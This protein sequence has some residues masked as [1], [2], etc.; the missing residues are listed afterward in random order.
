MSNIVLSHIVI[1]FA[2]VIA[3]AVVFRILHLPVVLG[4]LLVGAILGPH[5]LGVIKN[6]DVMERLAGFGV[7]F[8]MFTVG[9]EFSVAKLFA[10]R[11]AVFGLGGLQVL[12]SVILGMGI[13]TAMGMEWHS[14]LVVGGIVA[15]SSTA[16]VSK[17][18]SERLELNSK[19]GL[20][21]IGILLF[22]D[23][24]VIPLLIMVDSSTHES[25]A[26]LFGWAVLKG[27]IA[28]V[29]I[30]AIGR[31][32]MQPIF[33]MTAGTRVIELF[34][35]LVLFVALASA[36]LTNA[37][38]M[39]FPLGGFLA[40][41]MLAET[42]YSNQI[43]IEIRPFRDVLM[44][45][46]FV[47]IGM[48]LNVGT[49]QQTWLSILLL[50]LAIIVGKSI[51]VT[52]LC[53]LFGDDL[54]TSARCGVV[55]AQGGEFGFAL[56]AMAYKNQLLSA[57]SA[58]IILGAFI[59]SIAL[60]P[61]IIDHNRQIVAWVLPKALFISQKKKLHLLEK[62]TVDLRNHV[63]VCGYGR[64][65]QNVGHMLLQ[66]KIPYFA[67]DL[68]PTLIQS[69]GLSGENIG[70]GD[71]T[72]PH[73]L[74]AAGL[75]HASALVICFNNLRAASKILHT[76]RQHHRTLPIIVRCK[77]DVELKKL[78]SLGATHVIAESQ[79]ESLMM[80]FQLL[81]ALQIPWKK[82]A[83]FIKNVREKHADLLEE[84]FLGSIL[85]E[86]EEFN[87]DIIKQLR[88]VILPEQ[89][90]CV[91]VC[92][93]KLSSQLGEARIIALRRGKSYQNN[94]DP[95]ILIKPEDIVVLYGTAEQL[96]AAEEYLL[97]GNHS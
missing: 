5:A 18:L 62:K 90:F 53:K 39:S 60:A 7:V 36:W 97:S 68:D 71:S 28:I 66:E 88:P 50:L 17:Q 69:V 83:N 63:I 1:I 26:V 46:F 37:L 8:L 41:I 67:L 48:L 87:F 74:K 93:E 24:A 4:Y 13:A 32:L 52:V 34:T 72:H 76:V 27:I 47:A 20:N 91:G 15:M 96:D 6:V 94:P 65:G 85:K 92:L 84:I 12:I 80:T 25:L 70:Y 31:W 77:D 45:M 11:R 95:K 58:Q 75:K 55:L 89:A 49:W 78:R 73:I 54:A 35:L 57:G 38:G 16:I 9:L 61:V 40:G 19:Y 21:A 42:T 22:Q 44:G 81:L 23:L 59:L 29:A 33:R 43:E 56:L 82:A 64:V 10:L 2:L 86:E 79:E 3:A 14:A 51:L 30:M